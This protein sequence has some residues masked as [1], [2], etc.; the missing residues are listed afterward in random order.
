M[1]PIDSGQA[2][3]GPGTSTPPGYDFYRWERAAMV[4]QSTRCL[5]PLVSGNVLVVGN[6]LLAVVAPVLQALPAEKKLRPCNEVTVND[7][8]LPTKSHF[9]LL[10]HRDAPA[11]RHGRS[12]WDPNVT[13]LLAPWA[14]WQ[15]TKGLPTKHRDRGGP[16][17]NSHSRY[18]SVHRDSARR[19]KGKGSNENT[20]SSIQICQSV[21]LV[22]RFLPSVATSPFRYSAA[23]ISERG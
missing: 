4:K 17:R 12:P 1:L 18:S 10:R 8:E 9:V 6:F 5:V 22:R 14:P 23:Q 7:K 3:R 16:A 11:S 13:G 21:H 20:L 19:V 15:H 2:A